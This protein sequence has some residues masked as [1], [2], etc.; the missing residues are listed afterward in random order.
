VVV[1]VVMVVVVM[2]VVVMVV[3]VMVV[4]VRVVVVMVVV[5]SVVAPGLFIKSFSKALPLIFFE[6]VVKPLISL[7]L[8]IFDMNR[9]NKLY[10]FSGKRLCNA[11]NDRI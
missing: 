4:V 10:P 8:S 9:L 1:V 11:L 5:V 6:S 3:V 2:V 7:S